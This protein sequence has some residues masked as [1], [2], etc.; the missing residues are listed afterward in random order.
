MLLLIFLIL[1]CSV[2]IF[3]INSC[4][5][6]CKVSTFIF[7]SGML[8]VYFHSFIFIFFFIAL[9][10]FSICFF[11]KSLTIIFSV[12]CWREFWYLV[13]SFIDLKFMVR[14]TALW[15]L[16]NFWFSLYILENASTFEKTLVLACNLLLFLLFYL[17][18]VLFYSKWMS[19]HFYLGVCM[20]QLDCV[21]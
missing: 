12:M 16:D 2:A 9:S 8:R 21:F 11:V 3:I 14:P 19:F 7:D 15:S 4:I 20:C 10:I 13:F 17:H 1:R 5:L 6:I 18:F